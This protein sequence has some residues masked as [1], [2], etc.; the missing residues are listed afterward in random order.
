MGQ[1]VIVGKDTATSSLNSSFYPH[2]QDI[3]HLKEYFTR[4]D[5]YEKIK[6][7]VEPICLL[8]LL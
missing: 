2:N 8:L 1:G 3:D 5:I 4:S 7:I 6:Q